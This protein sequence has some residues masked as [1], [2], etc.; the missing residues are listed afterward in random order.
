MI[1]FK[2]KHKH[3]IT[4]SKILPA[5][6]IKI[7]GLKNFITDFNCI[8]PLMFADEIKKYKSILTLK[9]EIRDD[10]SGLHIETESLRFAR[11]FQNLLIYLTKYQNRYKNIIINKNNLF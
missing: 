8:E 11:A 5:I 9:R 3:I 6:F 4:H 2:K 7:K 10:L 1:R